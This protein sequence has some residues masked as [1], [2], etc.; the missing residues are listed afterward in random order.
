[1]AKMSKYT[2]AT[3]PADADITTLGQGG[4]TKKVALSVLKS[5][6]NSSDLLNNFA[7]SGAPGLGDDSADGYAVGSVWIDTAAS[8]KEAYRCASAG[9]GAAIWLKTTLTTDEL[10]TAALLNAEAATAANDFLVGGSSPLSW[11]RKTLAETLV[12][13]GIGNKADK[14]ATSPAPTGKVAQFDSGGNL[15]VSTKD[16]SDIH[17]LGADDQSLAGLAT[18]VA[19]SPAP[20]GLIATFDS[21]GNLAISAA[22][23]EDLVLS[24]DIQTIVKLTQA[25]YDALSPVDSA[26][27]YIIVE[28]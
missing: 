19:T 25:A 9:A 15:A 5:Y 11:I 20:T 2:A 27:L 23:V 10:G 16:A 13:L 21:S 14:V 18:K 7:G 3:T 8:P 28:A 17:A 26:T 1:M 12:I 4:V 6:F 24:E 22:E